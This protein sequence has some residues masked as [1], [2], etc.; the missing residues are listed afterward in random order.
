MCVRKICEYGPL[1]FEVKA[2]QRLLGDQVCQ[3][4]IRRVLHAS[5]RAAPPSAGTIHS[6]LSGCKSM[7]LAALQNTIQRP[8]GE[9][10][11]K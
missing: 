9:Y 2:S 10:L 4:F 7:K 3:E 1:T 6:S 11:A 5:R 8:S